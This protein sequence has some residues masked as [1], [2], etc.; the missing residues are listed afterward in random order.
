MT[1]K[2]H[3]TSLKAG[4]TLK[5]AKYIAYKLDKYFGLVGYPTIFCTDNEN[6]FTA[7]VVVNMLKNIN[8]S[9]LTVTGQPCTPRDQ[10]SIE[11]ANKL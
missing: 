1:M 9:I 11:Q 4:F 7:K 2:D 8:P 10:G 5:C 6:E 3:S